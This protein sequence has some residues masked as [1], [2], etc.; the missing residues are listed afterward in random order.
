MKT[1]MIILIFFLIGAFIIVNN[2]NLHLSKSDEFSKFGNQ[3]YSWLKQISSNTAQITGNIV[4]IEWLPK[5][6]IKNN[7]SE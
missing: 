5:E 3:Y 7:S 1:V 4:N 2:G 6:E